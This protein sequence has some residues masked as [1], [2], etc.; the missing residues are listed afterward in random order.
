MVSVLERLRV[1]SPPSSDSAVIQCEC[2][3]HV[4]RWNSKTQ[5]WTNSRHESLVDYPVLVVRIQPTPIPLLALPDLYSD[6]PYHHM[7]VDRNCAPTVRC[8]STRAY[9]PYCL[10]V[11]EVR[12]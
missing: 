1:A 12:G 2:G 8:T 10:R 5:T 7:P 11:L 3:A 4:W 6:R 9:C